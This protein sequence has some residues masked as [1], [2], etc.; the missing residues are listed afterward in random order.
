MKVFRL[1]LGTL[2]FRMPKY[3]KMNVTNHFT[4]QLLQLF[5]EIMTQ[6]RFFRREFPNGNTK[7]VIAVCRFPAFQITRTA[8]C[9]ALETW[10]VAL[11]KRFV[12]ISY[13]ASHGKVSGAFTNLVTWNWPWISQRK[14]V[15][16]HTQCTQWSW[17]CR[18]PPKETEAEEK[19]SRYVRRQHNWSRRWQQR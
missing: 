8:Q 11:M 7:W 18:R 10:N 12:R 2:W 17:I 15:W 9:L 1:E 5:Q 3:W 13:P 14:M 4:M 19:D 6:P 16:L